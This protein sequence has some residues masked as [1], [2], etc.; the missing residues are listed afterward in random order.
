MFGTLYDGEATDEPL[1]TGLGLTF[2][3]SPAQAAEYYHK[4]VDA[5]ASEAKPRL[6]AVCA[7]LQIRSDTLPQSAYE[8]YCGH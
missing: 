7:R 4:A 2:S 3:D 8:D 6:D 1:E 5:G